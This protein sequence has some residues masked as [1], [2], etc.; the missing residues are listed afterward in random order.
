MWVAVWPADEI[1][2]CRDSLSIRTVRSSASNLLHYT[3]VGATTATLPLS[4][5]CLLA[6]RTPLFFPAQGFRSRAYHAYTT[7]TTR[8]PAHHHHH[9]TPPLISNV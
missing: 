9:L 4:L 1:I 6:N 7:T 2:S 8:M 5:S 3:A